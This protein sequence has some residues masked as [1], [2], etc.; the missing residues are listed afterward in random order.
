MHYSSC[1]LEL[2]TRVVSIVYPSRAPV[3]VSAL[4]LYEEGPVVKL[5]LLPVGPRARS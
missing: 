2:S 3:K 4:P 1:L 5:H